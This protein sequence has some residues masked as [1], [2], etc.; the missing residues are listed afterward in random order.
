MTNI[1][2]AVVERNGRYLVGTRPAGTVLAGC[3]EFP[4][5]KCHPGESPE[6]CAVRECA[7]ET[8]LVVRSERQLACVEWRYPHGELALYFWLC[9]LQDLEAEPRPPFRWV[10]RAELAALPFPEANASVVAD[11]VKG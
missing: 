10:S 2:L 9:R 6:D 5:G 11:L 4:G 8:G 3:A 7:E 1:G